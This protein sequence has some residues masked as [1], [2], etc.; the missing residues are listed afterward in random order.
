VLKGDA[1]VRIAVGV[2]NNL[3]AEEKLAADALSRM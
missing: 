2:A 3:R 1:S